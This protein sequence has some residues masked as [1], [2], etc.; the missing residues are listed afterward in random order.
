LSRFRTISYDYWSFFNNSV[1]IWVTLYIHRDVLVWGQ[2]E[3]VVAN[4]VG[5]RNVSFVAWRHAAVTVARAAN[6]VVQTTAVQL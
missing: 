5:S 2:R 4:P 6:D 1:H 3:T